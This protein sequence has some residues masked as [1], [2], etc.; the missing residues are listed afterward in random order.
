MN[1]TVQQPPADLS[2]LLLPLDQELLVVPSAV[3]VEIIRR[4]ELLRLVQAPDWMLGMLHWQATMIPVLGFEALNGHD[5]EDDGHGGRLVVM[6]SIGANGAWENY[7]ILARG[8]PHLLLLTA[9]DVRVD[10][11]R[12]PGP[13]ERMKVRV[14][15]QNAAIPDLD[16]LETALR[17]HRD[18]S[19]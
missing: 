15:G 16:A 19:G 5:V 2:A 17:Q 6:S 1:T 11:S 18:T 14:H 8:V 7:A 3:V 9:A 4:R 10:A 12:S 13:M